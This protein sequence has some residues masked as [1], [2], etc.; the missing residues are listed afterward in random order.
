MRIGKKDFIIHRFISK[1]SIFLFFAMLSIT[2]ISLGIG[3]RS[4][5]RQDKLFQ[6]LR[7]NKRIFVAPA[8]PYMEENSIQVNFHNQLIKY[9]NKKI[10]KRPKIS[11]ETIVA[12]VFGQSNAGNYGGEKFIAET[13]NV[14][15]YFN[16]I[17]Y[18]AEDPLLG[19][20][21]EKGSVW[22]LTA[23]KLIKEKIAD[24]VILIPAAVGNTSVA[25]WKRGG[26]LNYM[27][28]SKL[29]EAKDNNLSI[30]HFLWHQGEADNPNGNSPKL[31][32]ADYEKGMKEIIL[33]TKKYF[34]RSKFIIAIASR[35]SFKMSSSIPLQIIQKNLTNMKGVYLGPNTDLIGLED[36]YD[37]CHLSGRG[38]QKHSDGWVKAIKSN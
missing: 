24:Q 19:S 15:N 17:F 35:C 31:G 36:R 8:K 14:Y 21:G 25:H 5:L 28:E 3:I 23:N 20:A 27:F 32:L 11:K 34:P 38:L 29:K 30:T 10:K 6:F 22:T 2:Y 37:N 16:E 1:K 12:F 13:Q 26:K 9:P 4:C 7:S 33:M 18:K